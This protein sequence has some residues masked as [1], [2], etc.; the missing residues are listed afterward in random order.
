M[1]ESHYPAAAGLLDT[2]TVTNKASLGVYLHT[3]A[4]REGYEPLDTLKEKLEIND[5]QLFDTM[6]NLIEGWGLDEEEASAFT[7]GFLIS[8]TALSFETELLDVNLPELEEAIADGF[9][10]KLEILQDSGDSYCKK[11]VSFLADNNPH[12]ID[13]WEDYYM[14]AG[15]H[16]SSKEKF[17]FII[18]GVMAHDIL[19]EQVNASQLVERYGMS[20]N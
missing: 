1:H 9:L 13:V 6:K 7:A 16:M 12:L 15:T 4:M 8:Y 10:A 19:R 18:G 14:S 5:P 3:K 17:S 11:Q 20:V 2:L